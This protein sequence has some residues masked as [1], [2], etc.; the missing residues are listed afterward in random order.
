MKNIEKYLIGGVIVLTVVMLFPV[1]LM[2]GCSPKS[3]TN[4]IVTNAGESVVTVMY[5]RHE[6]GA[7]ER[8]L[9]IVDVEHGNVVY[10]WDAPGYGGGCAVMPLKKSKD[11]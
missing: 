9:R 7:T 5:H 4:A 1:I 3:K 6:S 11:E 2:F 10:C 8:L